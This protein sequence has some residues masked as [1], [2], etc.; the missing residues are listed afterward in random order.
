MRA[1]S[2]IMSCFIVLSAFV[3]KS[4]VAFKTILVNDKSAHIKID[5]FGNT[6]VITKTEI[7]KYTINGL[8]VKS[9]S[10]KRYGSIDFVD[11]T[12]PL[13]ILVYY[14]D[15]QQILF[16]DNQLTASSN[17]ISL[18]NLGLEQTS[19]VCTSVNNSFWLF[20]KQNNSLLRFNE[21]S[22]QLVKIDNLKRILDLDL[23]PNFLKE[24]NNYL[25][26]NCPDEGILVFDMYGSF[27]KTI[28]I[29]NLIEFD[30]QNENII[31]FKDNYLNEYK[32]KTFSTNHKFFKDSLLKTVYWQGNYFYNVYQDSVTQVLNRD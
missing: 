10:A 27:L 21:K 31:Y 26:L 7:L 23:K 16:L 4:D 13:K 15:F 11:V 29:K 2:I 32:T 14:K 5:D 12:N 1:F 28:P 6:Y 24:K 3:I 22:N 20:D 19:L 9:F 8:F 18:E 17:M 30:V 25:Y